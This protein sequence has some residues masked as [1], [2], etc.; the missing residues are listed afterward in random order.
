MTRVGTPLYIA[1][2]LVQNNKYSFKVDVWSVGCLLYQMV[3]GEVPFKSSNLIT[4]GN[5][6]VF[7]NHV[8]LKCS[9]KLKKLIDGCL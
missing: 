4:L 3:S 8:P 6:I 2:E 5:K 1:P 7:S 9:H